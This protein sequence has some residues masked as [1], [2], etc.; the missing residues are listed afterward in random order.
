M[1]NIILLAL[2]ILTFQL[3]AQT[4][5]ERAMD[6]SK[7]ITKEVSSNHFNPESLLSMK[8]HKLDSVLA[9]TDNDI[10]TVK[11][12][13]EYN[14]EGNT[15][16][17]RQFEKD[18]FSSALILTTVV[19][20]EYDNGPNPTHVTIDGLNEDTHLLERQAEYDAFYDGLGRVDSLV[21]SVADPL[22]GVFAELIA[23]KYVY[24]GDLLDLTRQWFN[25]GAWLLFTVTDNIYNN[26][27][28][29]IEA[30]TQA[31][32]FQ[33]FLLENTTRTTY[34]YTGNGLT[35]ASTTFYWED[36]NWIQESQILYE[37]YANG[38]LQSEITQ[39]YFN[40]EWV[41]NTRTLYH[42]DVVDDEFDATAYSWVNDAWAKTD[43]THHILNPLLPWENVASPTG[44][45]ILPEIGS[46]ADAFLGF[47]ESS[48]VETELFAF[49]SITGEFY[50]T[51][52]DIFFYSLFDPTRVETVLP[53][54]LRVSPNPSSTDLIIHLDADHIGVYTV[55]SL[56]GQRITSGELGNGATVIKSGN[57]TPGMYIILFDFQDGTKY[58]HKQVI[59]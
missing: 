57:W 51:E 55:T 3:A 4:G 49:N 53:D 18:S 41:N 16:V 56:S 13:F 2:S 31:L 12:E 9:L 25:L 54:Y 43:S 19:T 44:F 15:T 38:T 36:P 24:D 6:L 42:Q 30:I 32:N 17:M 22:T 27:D 5:F 23:I 35:E 28:L 21:I 1:K 10:I 50:L 20:S 14:A 52:R 7:K 39:D 59:E 29:L 11:I 45:S 40:G 8:T 26:D 47:S 37:Y 58:V 33:T 46:V 48:I 34:S